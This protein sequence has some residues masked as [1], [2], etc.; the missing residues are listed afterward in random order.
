M[1]YNK[2]EIDTKKCYTLYLYIYLSTYIRI[3]IYYAFIAYLYY[4]IQIKPTQN[5]F[6]S[7]TV[8]SIV[9]ILFWVGMDTL[10]GK[11]CFKTTKL[12]F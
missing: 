4:T 1:H 2:N 11:L 9:M 10:L 5:R 8:S 7:L 6:T 3:V 12:Y